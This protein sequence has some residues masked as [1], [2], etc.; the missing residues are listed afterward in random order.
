MSRIEGIFFNL[1]SELFERILKGP[2][3]FFFFRD[4]APNSFLG[5][6]IWRLH[7]LFGNQIS[8]K[9]DRSLQNSPKKYK[10]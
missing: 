9:D 10:K 1:S 5:P 3:V 4:L 6:Q 8:K 7:F 2:I